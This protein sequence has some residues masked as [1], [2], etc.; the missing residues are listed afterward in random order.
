MLLHLVNTVA[1][2]SQ[3]PDGRTVYGSVARCGTR[4]VSVVPFQV[5]QKAAT[6]KP[7]H[8]ACPL[9]FREEAQ[10]PRM[11]ALYDAGPMT[12]CDHEGNPLPPPLSDDDLGRP[13]EDRHN[14]VKK[15]ISNDFM[16]YRSQ[17]ST[18]FSDDGLGEVVEG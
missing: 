17:A 10:G 16:D 3:L 4:L 8:A 12:E 9:C 18:P 7:P 11:P 5:G 15:E 13:T 6:G 1:G 14:V 2:T